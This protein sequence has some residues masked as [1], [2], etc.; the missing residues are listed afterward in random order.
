MS[1]RTRRRFLQ[2][3]LATGAAALAG[4]L[5]SGAELDSGAET[6]EGA[7]GPSDWTYAGRGSA[8]DVPTVAADVPLSEDLGAYISNAQSGG[9]ERDGIPSLEDPDF[10]D[11]DH[12]DEMMD[13]GDPVFGLVVDGVARAY[14]QHIL[15]WHEIANDTIAGL[16]VAV[17]YCPL[18][19]T[20]LAFERGETEFGV[21]GR[22][23]NS[24]LIMYDRAIGAWWPQVLGTAVFGE[25]QGRSLRELPLVWTSWGNWRD[26]YP[27][28]EVMT[29]NTDTARDYTRDP[30]GEYNPP[31]G[32]YDSGGP[33]F[34][35]MHEDDTYEDKRVV[36]GGRS[37]DG[38]FAV[39]KDHLLD[40][41][42]IEG[43]VGGVE[44]AFVADH[45]LETGYAYRNP[46]G[47][48]IDP[49]RSGYDVGGE[50]TPADDLP[51]E[52]INTFDAMWFAMPAFYPDVTVY[53]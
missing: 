6:S 52:R 30:Y 50:F 11:A 23:V 26:T 32:Y 28:T 39:A 22:L 13:D 38:V 16:P 41:D 46:E 27:E 18:T 21:S 20:A 14:P 4:C 47:V 51:L 10:G 45:D 33:T 29:T 15:V 8:D 7:A 12:G 1:D 24:S 44:Y 5:G 43:S 31:G 17:T 19:G 53:E 37:R 42:V 49:E 25:L 35:V 48:A 34:D 36:I 40:A 9:V 3:G 2:A